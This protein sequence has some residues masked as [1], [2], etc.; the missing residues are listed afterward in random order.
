MKKQLR[1][2]NIWHFLDGKAGHENQVIGLIQALQER[3]SVSIYSILSLPTTKAAWHLLRGSFPQVSALPRPHLL[4]GA[5]HQTHLSLLA[6]RRAYGGRIIVLMKPTLPLSLFDLCIIPEHDNPPNRSNVFVTK[7]TVNRIR[8]SLLPR[9]RRGLILVGGHSEHFDWQN[10]T[11]IQ[12][13]K[14][15]VLET[16]TLHWTLTISRR[17]PPNF[18]SMLETNVLPLLTVMPFDKTQPHAVP[19]ALSQCEQA[20]ITPDSVAMVYEALT[21]GAPVGVF[22]LVPRTA[23][24]NV[25]RGLQQLIQAQMVQTFQGWQK[26]KKIFL[27]KAQLHEA[28]RVSEWMVQEWLH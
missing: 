2:F 5:G 10:Q 23:H 14:Q 7:G 1:G 6:A 9:Q 16:P 25:Y 8:P 20:W 28:A 22:D 11:I 4:I 15:L 18:L 21:S 19:E 3:T 13:I 26:T 17:T 24:S 12:Q 27:P